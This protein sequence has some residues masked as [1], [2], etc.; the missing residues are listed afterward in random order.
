MTAP[1]EIESINK[2]LQAVCRLA[3]KYSIQ[4]KHLQNHIRYLMVHTASEME[5][6]ITQTKINLLTG[7]KREEISKYLKVEPPKFEQD[8][9]AILL[10][11]LWDAKDNDDTLPLK[12]EK[13][14]YSIA[15][16]TVNGHYPPS[17]AFDKLEENNTIELIGDRVLVKTKSLI[18]T[19][20]FYKSLNELSAGASFHIDTGLHNI[21]TKSIPDKMSQKNILSTQIPNSIH[22]KAH[23][24]T[25]AFIENFWGELQYLID[26]FETDVDEGTYEVFGVSI[27]EH[28]DFLNSI[29]K[30]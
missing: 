24:E 6:G 12:G 15:K 4:T 18:F 17:D 19:D 26:S 1:K 7:I 20:D 13:S 25:K 3:C 2:L 23:K 5:P 9:L 8:K 10:R 14:F 22:K 30:V 29:K 11:R 16:R 21:N 28:S 27:V